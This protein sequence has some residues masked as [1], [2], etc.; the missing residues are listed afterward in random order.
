MSPL[1]EE[2]LVRTAWLAAATSLILGVAAQ[3]HVGPVG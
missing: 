1:T 3:L 2:L